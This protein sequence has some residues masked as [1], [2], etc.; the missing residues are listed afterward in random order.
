MRLPYLGI[1]QRRGNAVGNDSALRDRRDSDEGHLL[2]ARASPA[3][4][5]LTPISSRPTSPAAAGALPIMVE[6]FPV[7]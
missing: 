4:G 2:D 6:T 5:S 7:R 3:S 1:P